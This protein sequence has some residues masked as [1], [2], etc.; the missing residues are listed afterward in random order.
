MGAVRIRIP[1]PL[2]HAKTSL[3][4]EIVD[5]GQLRMEPCVITD[6]E[7][8]GLWNGDL[9]TGFVIGIIAIRDERID[10]VIASRKLE[11]NQDRT[12]L[13]RG[14]L[15]RSRGSHGVET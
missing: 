9:G 3:G 14:D 8:V 4:I 1:Y 11:N 5:S 10:T 2:D 13:P 12:I 7:D 6:T 15:P